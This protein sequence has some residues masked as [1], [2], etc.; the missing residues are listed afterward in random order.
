VTTDRDFERLC[1]DEPFAYTNPVP[2]DVLS[3]FD[4]TT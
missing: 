2:E 4:T 3:E 1:E